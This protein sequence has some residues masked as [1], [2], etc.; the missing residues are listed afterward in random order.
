MTILLTAILCLLGAVVVFTAITNGASI[1]SRLRRPVPD[2]LRPACRDKLAWCLTS[3]V[4]T[5]LL[6][7][8]V[9]CL[10]YP[11][12]KVADRRSRSPWRGTGPV[13]VCL[14]G[15]YHNPA[16]F[17]RLRPALIRAGLPRVLCPG[18]SCLGTDFEDVVRALLG[19]LRAEVP[20]QAPLLF[21]GHSL[22]GLVARRLAAESDMA[23]RT[24]ALVTLGAPHGGSA[25]AALAVGR[26]GRGLI[27]AGPIPAAVATLVDPP[28]AA[29]L[30]LA[31]PVDN[32]VVPLDGLAVGRPAWD[33][34]AA[35]PVSHVSLLYHPAV[36]ARAVDFLVRAAKA[37]P[38][39]RQIEG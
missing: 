16:A 38:T 5:T 33:E 13:V 19:R 26:L 8:L 30:S 25:L 4:V 18:Y 7:Q 15:L 34:E 21:V 22:G 3:G 27:P 29:L 12:G 2:F 14:H 1:I 31:S 28:G 37:G 20:A 17:L 39:S 23:G 6:S 24:V 11:L 35:P 10:T 9:M 36:I 32:L